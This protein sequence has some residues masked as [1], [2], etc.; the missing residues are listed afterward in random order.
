MEDRKLWV[1]KE[2]GV[3]FTMR[4]PESV[5]AML[6]KLGDVD[7]PNAREAVRQSVYAVHWA[8]FVEE[9]F[10]NFTVERLFAA[11]FLGSLQSVD[12]EEGVLKELDSVVEFL[13]KAI[14]SARVEAAKGREQIKTVKL[15]LVAKSLAA[16]NILQDLKAGTIS[17]AQADE[18]MLMKVGLSVTAFR[19]YMKSAYSIP[20]FIS[21]ENGTRVMKLGDFETERENHETD[22]FDTGTNREG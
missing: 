5:A 12:D 4:I 14:L 11:G 16:G 13:E 20:F 8:S 6:P 21:D 7:K 3:T 1:D 15:Q 22:H 2:P 17:D 10:R 19:K 18:Q 9:H